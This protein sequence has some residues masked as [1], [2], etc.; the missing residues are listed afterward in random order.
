MSKPIILSKY[1]RLTDAETWRKICIGTAFSCVTG[2]LNGL[3]LLLLL[4]LSMSLVTAQ[5]VWGFGFWCWVC[6]LAA[7]TL[8]TIIV[9]FSATRTSYIGALGFLSGIHSLIGKKISS[10]PLGWFRDDSSA[11]LSRMV[12]QELVSLSEALA[13][14][15]RELA[16]SIFS[17]LVIVVGSWFWDWHL[18]LMLTIAIP[19]LILIL[20]L[21]RKCI[22]KGAGYA[23]QAEEEVAARIVEFSRCQGALRLANSRDGYPELQRAVKDCE[24]KSHTGLWIE[25][26]G[27]VLS[28]NINQCII[29]TLIFIAGILA[30][31]G[32]LHP[33]AAI[34]MIGLSLRFTTMLEAIATG[35]AGMATR[36][37]LMT[38]IS[39]VMEADVL[40]VVDESAPQPTPGTVTFDHVDFSY[41]AGTPILHDINFVVPQHSMCALVGPSGSGKTTIAKLVARFYDATDGK[42][43]VGGVDVKD[44]TTEDLMAQLSMVF[45]NVYLFDDTLEANIR[46]GNEDA[47][48]EQVRWASDLAGVSEIVERLPMGWESRVG[49][50]GR[51]LSGGERQRVSIARAL[52]K[53]APIVL[54]DEATSALDAENEAHFVASMQELRRNSTLIV[55]AHKLETIKTADQLIVLDDNG[56]ICQHGTHDDLVAVD[57]QYRRFWESRSQAA[58]WELTTI[59]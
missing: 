59:D 6:I 51:S 4:P 21:S 12:S 54:F 52:L 42:V 26:L 48:A 36:H 20:W 49:E 30:I 38:H 56:R 43:L 27:Q 24:T 25:T 41:V 16:I 19:V 57:G 39:E 34:A 7:I 32:T 15:T 40:P 14:F 45:Q 18:G 50:G 3:A 47:S 10:L 8:V 1:R 31:N 35:L 2:A 29:A 44:L 37:A 23:E 5:P 28:G 55:I 33:V 46:L 11:S 53:Q 17:C 58:G 13:H 9:D 22:R